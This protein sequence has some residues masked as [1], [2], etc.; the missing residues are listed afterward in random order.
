MAIEMEKLEELQE[1]AWN[2]REQL[3]WGCDIAKESDLRFFLSRLT[4]DELA[5]VRRS[6]QLKGISSLKKNELVERLAEEIVAGL[7]R[8]LGDLNLE[9]YEIVKRLVAAGGSMSGQNFNDGCVV[10]FR[11]RGL[12]FSGLKDGERQLLMPSEV[13][14]EL[15]TLDQTA[16]AKQ[17]AANDE[18]M[19]LVHGMLYYYGAMSLAQIMDQL[20]VLERAKGFDEIRLDR[21]LRE[22]AAVYYDLIACDKDIFFHLLADQERVR[23]EHDLRSSLPWRAFTPR[24]LCLAGQ[25]GFVEKTEAFLRLA[26][27]IGE[28]YAITRGEA[29]GLVEECVVAINDGY[30]LTELVELLQESLEMDSE[31][32]VQDFVALLTYLV[33]NTR[34]WGLKGHT[35]AELSIRDLAYKNVLQLPLAKTPLAA[36]KTVGRNEPCLCGSGKKF[37]KCCGNS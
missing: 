25:V 10:F 13:V 28:Y 4:K 32:I 16:L 9:Q 12:F 18:C 14:K 27:F 8:L 1:K 35:P 3:L 2:K 17:A 23:A 34:Q 20:K 22:N 21:L 6:L 5:D 30:S 36:G 24:H 11:K 33:N 7:P 19:T 26:E 15:S 29:E 31:G 37:K